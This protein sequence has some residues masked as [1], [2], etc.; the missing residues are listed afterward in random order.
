MVC[1]IDDREDVWNDAP[2]LIRVKPY[3]F[4][5]GVGDINAPPGQDVPNEK[6]DSSSEPSAPKEK[7]DATTTGNLNTQQD[8]IQTNHDPVKGIDGESIVTETGMK[9]EPEDNNICNTINDGQS[10]TCKEEQRTEMTS[11]KD[12]VVTVVHGASDSNKKET[13]ALTNG[14][15]DK[16]SSSSEE[17]PRGRSQNAVE[18]DPTENSQG[19]LSKK[20]V[21]HSILQLCHVLVYGNSCRW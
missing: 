5:K 17:V 8:T 19:L 2:N 14:S 3:Q 20:N 1:I 12:L 4:F 7:P 15:Q 6:Q 9:V 18:H 21:T 16:G 10:E 11:A 13:D